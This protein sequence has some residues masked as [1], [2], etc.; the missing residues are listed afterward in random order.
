[1]DSNN[2]IFKINYILPIN[3]TDEDGLGKFTHGVI[4]NWGDNAKT[5]II[6]KNISS[7][8]CFDHGNHNPKSEYILSNL[9]LCH[10]HL[11]SHE[12]Y[13]KKIQSNVT[14]LGYNYKLNDLKLLSSDCAGNHHVRSAILLLENPNHLFENKINSYIKPDWIYIKHI[15]FPRYSNLLSQYSIVL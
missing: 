8:L 7:K 14:G 13:V 2:G 4:G 12:S 11:R 10:F 1:M 3:V 5:F 9:M 15:L 6:K